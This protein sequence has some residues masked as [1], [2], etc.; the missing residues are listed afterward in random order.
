MVYTPRFNVKY[1]FNPNSILRLAAGKGFRVANPIAENV[2][3]LI[4]NRDFVLPN[5]LEPEKAWNLGGSFTQYFEVGN[6]KGAFI[7]D[8]Y[9]TTF[10]NQVVPDMYTNPNQVQFSNLVGRSFSKSFQAELQYELTEMLDVKAAYKYFDVKTSYNGQLLQRPFI[11]NHRAFV[12]LG[13]A[14]PFDKWRADLT[15]QWFGK[16]LVPLM[17]H[18]HEGEIRT[19]SV[20]PYAAFNGQITR[21]FKRW[22]VY[23]GGENLLGYTQKNPILGADQ[24]FSQHFDV[25]MIYA[26]I[27]GR[28][29]YAG[30]RITIK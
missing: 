7:T 30:L 23:V 14:T 8:Y 25:S 24:P 1:D 28:V 18:Q 11:P 12:N 19:R 26:P 5:N 6:R 20:S 13:F 22:E 21:A 16:R 10:Q 2:A 3:S 15:A 9:Y 29:I 17:E 27:I 4:S